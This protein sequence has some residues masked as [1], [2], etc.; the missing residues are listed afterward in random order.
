MIEQAMR[1]NNVEIYLV[2]G[3]VRDELLKLPVRERDWVVIGATPDEL[4]ARGFRPV[5]VVRRLRAGRASQ[6]QSKGSPASDQS[7][8]STAI[9]S[10]VTRW[11]SAAAMNG[12]RSPSST[13]EGVGLVTPVR[14]SL[15]IW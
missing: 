12:S 2:G 9:F 4:L 11:A 7:T 14:R 15:T 5:K 13:S 6:S 1:M 8:S 3:A 10:P